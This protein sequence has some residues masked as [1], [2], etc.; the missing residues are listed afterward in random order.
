MPSLLLW[1]DEVSDDHLSLVGGKALNL[2]RLRR[3]GFQVPNGFVLTTTVC[4]QA[5]QQEAPNI[6]PPEIRA[7]L[8]GRYRRLG[9]PAVAVRSSAT[10]ED[11]ASASFAGQGR[12]ILNVRGEE[13][14]LEAVAEVWRSMDRPAARAYARRMQ[15]ESENVAVAVLVQEM[16]DAQVSGVLFTTNPLTG[17]N[18][19]MVANATWGLG[20]PLVS[21]QVTPDEVVIDT[22]DGHCKSTTVGSKEQILTTSGLKPADTELANTFCLNDQLIAQLIEAGRKIEEHFGAP[23]DVEWAWDG[24]LH[25]LQ[26]RPLTT[27]PLADE[28]D[29]LWKGELARLQ[30]QPRAH[31]NIWVAKGMAELLPCPTPLSWEVASRLMSGEEGFGLA[32]RYLGF[33]PVPGTILERVAGHIYVD[34]DREIGLFFQHA[35]IGYAK[36]E[37]RENPMR[38]SVPRQVLDWRKLGPHLLVYLP[39]VVLRVI[40]FMWGLRRH[41]REF[42]PFFR[43]RFVPEFKGYIEAETKKDVTALSGKHLVDLFEQRSGH[44][45]TRSSPILMAGSILSAMGYRELEDLL[46]ERLGSQGA[47]LAQQLTSGLEPNPALEMARA[48]ISVARGETSEDVFLDA[49]GH[50]CGNEFEL[51]VPRWREDRGSLRAQVEQ[52]A[53]THQEDELPA[54][55]QAA[56]QNAESRLQ[57]LQAQWGRVARDLVGTHLRT[58]QQLFPLREQTKNLLMKEYE[59]LRLP[60]VELDRQ[61]SLEEGIFYLSLSELEPA[62]R[63]EPVTDIIAE[64]RARHALEQQ[65]RLPRVI[66][67]T[68][69]AE[70][71]D[72]LGAAAAGELRGVGVSPGVAQG[73]M[74][75]VR[76]VDEL[77]AVEPGEILAV[78]SLEPSWTTAFVRAR[79]LVAERGATLS[80]GAIVAREFGIPAVVNVP[81]ATSRLHNGQRVSVNGTT[82]TVRL[83]D[84]QR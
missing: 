4:R 84:E 53:H 67:G 41:R 9:C 65:L 83:S 28:A 49:F 80:H 79:G 26:S 63:G 68:Q 2:A 21:G 30:S 78:E 33:D 74:R 23:Q 37:I 12:T 10:V 36:K 31:S 58:A 69:L 15:A 6:L 44:F 34:L 19:E 25:V 56:R 73:R 76:T 57:V 52:L 32:Q 81:Q 17:A 77:S 38:A 64:R 24:R 14:L 50:R 66:L 27:V 54:R 55:G 22:T 60:L 13:A 40:R 47:E 16:V 39:V 5:K 42:L 75:V 11:S 45:L 18:D 71:R 43:E 51:A 8:I 3:A 20:E 7:E 70:L 1:L 48:M 59:L 35:P 61:L 29:T 72:G 62:T 82:G 46:I